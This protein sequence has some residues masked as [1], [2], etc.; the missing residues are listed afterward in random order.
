MIE[1]KGKRL[2][3]RSTRLPDGRG[4]GAVAA[5]GQG[6]NGAKGKT[7]EPMRGGSV[8]RVSRVSRISGVSVSR[9][10]YGLVLVLGAQGVQRH[11]YATNAIRCDA[12]E[13]T[14]SR[15][16]RTGHPREVRGSR[17]DRGCGPVHGGGFR[18]SGGDGGIGGSATGTILVNFVSGVTALGGAEVKPAMDRCKVCGAEVRNRP[19]P[20]RRRLTCGRPRAVQW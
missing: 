4:R 17:C 13:R 9:I 14:G 11:A 20:G 19:G 1:T 8:S 2:S 16:W 3:T 18:F 5:E 7:K 12:T 15:S 10:G 6:R